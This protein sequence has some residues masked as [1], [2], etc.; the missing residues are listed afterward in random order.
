[1][2]NSMKD[3]AAKQGANVIL[4]SADLSVARQQGQVTDF[5]SKRVNA[6]VLC[7]A[8]SKAIGTSIAE[9]HAAGIPV[10]TADIAAISGGDS[11]IC[12]VATDNHAGDAK[13]DKP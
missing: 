13:P 9:A 8:D 4:T 11:V 2:G 12:H 6:I 5:I 7:P 1:M 3:E 10:F